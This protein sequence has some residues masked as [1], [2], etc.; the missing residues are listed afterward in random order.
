M[1]AG[2]VREG[3]VTHPG[4]D[5]AGGYLNHHGGGVV[6]TIALQGRNMPVDQFGN[7]A[8]KEEIYR[9]SFPCAGLRKP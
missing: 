2:G 5:V 9:G 3:A 4:N 6:Y 1:P 8:L 7:L